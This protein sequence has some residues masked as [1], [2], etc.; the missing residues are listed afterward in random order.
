MLVRPMVAAVDVTFACTVVMW[1]LACTVVSWPQC[2]HD[3]GLICRVRL[4]FRVTISVL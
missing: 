2:G 1:S 4:L 3:V